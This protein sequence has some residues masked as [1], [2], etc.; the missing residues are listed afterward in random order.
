MTSKRNVSRIMGDSGP[1]MHHQ[2]LGD[3]EKICAFINSISLKKLI[4]V[5]HLAVKAEISDKS[6]KNILQ[7]L[8]GQQIILSTQTRCK[9]K[10]YKKENRVTIQDIEDAQ[11]YR[12]YK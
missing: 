12:I 1:I 7:V 8:A 5:R 3:A 6:A 2:R 10:Y 11:L 9:K 4:I